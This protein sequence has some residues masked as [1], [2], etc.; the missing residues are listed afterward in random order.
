MIR[1]TSPPGSTTAPRL[2]V[3]DQIRAQF[4]W[5]GVTGTMA[6]RSCGTRHLVGRFGA[7]ETLKQNRSADAI[8]L[9]RTT[10]ARGAGFIRCCQSD[11]LKSRPRAHREASPELA[12]PL[13]EALPFHSPPISRPD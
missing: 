3:S 12:G 7:D 11:S 2:L 4:C 5:K 8:A 9:P 6:A 10:W 13:E 1:S